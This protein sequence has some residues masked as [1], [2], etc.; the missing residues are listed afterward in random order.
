[1]N[2]FRLFLTAVSL[3][4][5]GTACGRAVEITQGPV[6]QPTPTNAVIR[7]TTDRAAGGRV[8]YGTSVLQMA[9]R[10]SA[11]AVSSQQEVRIQGLKPGT[12]YWYAVG[13]ARLTLATNSFTTPGMTSEP[14]TSAR[15]DREATAAK[16]L[17]PGGGAAGK[18]D[19]AKV[20]APPARQTWGAPRTLQDHF[21]RHGADFAAKNPED[22]AA[23][24]WIFLR[25][26][27]VEGLPA[28]VDDDGVLRVYEPKTRSFAAY[29]KDLTTRTYFKPGRRDYF[30]DQPGRPVD[31][32]QWV[33]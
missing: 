29:N 18:F 4:I 16:S 3:W 31:L 19:P 22:Y 1:M 17:V 24:A 2:G 21:D 14:A 26:A 13:T 12:T 8:V 23:Q 20:Q 30:D 5:L 32:N 11:D 15:R 7:W 25:R 6:V 28:K 33:K 10:A 9:Q 27:K